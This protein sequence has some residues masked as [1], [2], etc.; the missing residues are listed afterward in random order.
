MMTITWGIT[1]TRMGRASGNTGLRTNTSV[2]LLSW[3]LSSFNYFCCVSVF[4]CHNNVK[5]C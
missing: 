2:F 4:L 1:W 5:C 3:Y